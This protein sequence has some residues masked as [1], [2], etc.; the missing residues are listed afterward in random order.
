MHRSTP[1]RG[2]FVPLFVVGVLALAVWMLLSRSSVPQTPPTTATAIIAQ[3]SAVTLAAPDTP[4]SEST[5]APPME[6]Q[7]AVIAETPTF[8]APAAL[9][10]PTKIP[11]KPPESP[12]P[13]AT[14]VRGPP[15]QIDGLRVITSEELPPEALETLALIA[16]GGPFPFSK[17]GSVFQNREQLLPRKPSGYYREYT[18]ITPGESDRGAR[19]IVRGA[20]GELYYTEDHYASFARIWMP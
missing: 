10:A 20:A 14:P 3:A 2:G 12:R 7:V 1:R 17:D 19:R 8:E 18:V 13:T 5:P 16:R 15:A 4:T 9:T 11:T 6:P